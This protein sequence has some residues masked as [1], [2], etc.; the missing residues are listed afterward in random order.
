MQLGGGFFRLLTINTVVMLGVC[1]L[2]QVLPGSLYTWVFGPQ[3]E[4][5]KSFLVVLVFGSLFY[6]IFLLTSYWH[7]SL[8][9]FRNNLI[10][11]F[12]GLIINVIG[13]LFL[14]STNQLTLPNIALLTVGSSL[15]IAALAILLFRKE[16]SILFTHS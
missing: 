1:F 13:V 8:G 5:V 14:T 11:G 3:F 4:G 10:A 15:S 2:I 6:S 7:S 12:G 16:R 9:K